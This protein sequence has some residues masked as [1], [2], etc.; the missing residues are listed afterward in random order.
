MLN[1]SPNSMTLVQY[2]VSDSYSTT[3]GNS[4]ATFYG[5]GGIPH[6]R[7]DGTG[8]C[9]GYGGPA[10]YDSNFAAALATATDVTITP[11]IAD[12]GGGIYKAI[13]TVCIEETGAGKSM[14][15]YMAQVLDYWP[16]N[17]T[18]HRNGFK[19]AAATQDVTLDPGEC[20]EVV[21]NFSFDATSWLDP[22]NIL[23]IIWAQQISGGAQVYQG[24]RLI[25]PDIYTPDPDPMTFASP[26]G[27]S[28]PYAMIMIATRATDRSPPVEYYFECT[29]GAGGTDSDWRTQTTY[30]DTGGGALL[31]PDT[32]YSYRTKARDSAVPPNETE[33]SGVFSSTTRAAPPAAPLVSNV[34]TDS[35]DLDLDPGT[36]PAHTDHAIWCSSSGD[37]AWDGMWL[38]ASG[39][40]A[41]AEVWQTDPEWGTVALAGLLPG[42]QYCFRSKAINGDGYES[43]V[44]TEYCA[45]TQ[46]VTVVTIDAATSWTDQG[47][48]P[49]GLELNSEN[50]EPRFTGV[51]ELELTLSEVVAT[52]NGATVACQENP[53]LTP[54]IQSVTLTGGDTVTVVFAAPL[55]DADCC[56]V[57]LEDDADGASFSVRPLIGDMNRNGLVANDDKSLVKFTIGEVLGAGNFWKDVNCNGVIANDDKSLVKFRVGNAATCAK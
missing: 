51:T 36:N 48:V 34:T 41:A 43:A 53:G 49:Y 13:A 35:M 21:R 12:L 31:T 2:H 26:P 18:Y 20:T 47:G 4:R 16:A 40:P 29:G 25:L 15:I 11:T 37:P 23:I 46:S 9:V 38:D 39:A 52:V 14:R 28:S 30:V 1:S 45:T 10:C 3:W 5:V 24:A 22:K 32:Q 8:T 42:T 17:P 50:I 54:L 56:T 19:Q 6:C 55:P 33:W 44:G 27:A 7:F 57:T